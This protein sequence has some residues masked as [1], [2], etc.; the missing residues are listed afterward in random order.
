MSENTSENPGNHPGAVDDEDLPVDLQPSEDNPLAEP[1]DPEEAR[2]P[3][4]LDLQGGKVPEEL[5]DAP[6]EDETDR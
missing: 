1:L 3:E 5:A 6:D 2:S 4:E